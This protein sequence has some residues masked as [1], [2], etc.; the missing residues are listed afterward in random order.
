VEGFIYGWRGEARFSISTSTL[1]MEIVYFSGILA[2]S[3]A[4]KHRTSL[5]IPPGNL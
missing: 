5:F 1:K 4:P 3:T 2:L